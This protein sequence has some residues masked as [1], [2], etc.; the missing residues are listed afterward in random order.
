MVYFS[1]HSIL[2]NDGHWY[3]VGKFKSTPA[4]PETDIVFFQPPFAQYVLEFPAVKTKGIR[5]L[6]D[7]KVQ[8]HWHKYTKNVSSFISIPSWEFMRNKGGEE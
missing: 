5:V 4:L 6:M 2:G 1:K 7:A 8:E 3:D